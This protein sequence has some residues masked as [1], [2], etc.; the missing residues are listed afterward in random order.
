MKLRSQLRIEEDN[1]ND[2]Y[3]SLRHVRST[4]TNRLQYQLVMLNRKRKNK[5]VI[6]IKTIFRQ[7]GISSSLKFQQ[8]HLQHCF[9]IQ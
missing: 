6:P 9:R 7:Q 2:K 1:L 8:S 3:L 4:S 5:V